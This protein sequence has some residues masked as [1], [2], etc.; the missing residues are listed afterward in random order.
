MSTNSVALFAVISLLVGTD[1]SFD[2]VWT[3]ATG[4]DG[5]NEWHST[6]VRYSVPSPSVGT[7]DSE[8][9]ILAELR[10]A[11]Q[12]VAA[13]ETHLSTQR[14]SRASLSA[15]Q[16]RAS[17][18]SRYQRIA[19]LAVLFGLSTL[20]FAFA[21]HTIRE[22]ESKR[23]EIDP[24][25][26][27]DIP[28]MSRIL[29]ACALL[30]VL[31]GIF[32]FT[33][34]FVFTESERYLSTAEALYLS[35]QTITAVGYGD[36]N[37]AT[38]EGKIFMLFY[39]LVA[40]ALIGALLQNVITHYI[41]FHVHAEN[42]KHLSRFEIAL[43]STKPLILCIVFGTLFYA[44][45]PGE[46]KTMFES[47]YMSVVTLSNI[48]FGQ[49]H[50]VTEVGQIVASVWMI[51]GVVCFFKFMG[52]FT[53]ALFQHRRNIRSEA[54]AW[55]VFNEIDKS[56]NGYITRVQFL[57]YDLI[58]GGLERVRFEKALKKFN[59]FDLKHNHLLDFEEFKQYIENP[60]SDSPAATQNLQESDSSS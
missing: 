45:C 25:W 10:L 42:D 39:V 29:G 30:Y 1:A 22:Y 7:S 13:L 3:S 2:Q 32:C 51:V 37:P 59:K 16:Q 34:I 46:D 11:K 57:G 44:Y 33:E 6:C 17:P 9:Q 21:W 28:C 19:K 47:L 15:Q 54:A 4:L 31:L 24:P 40:V 38:I 20:G 58:Q 23:D 12:R 56:H 50:P 52:D 60:D 5:D 55:K 41:E 35:S 26:F 43:S 27:H 49:H 14:S 18:S 36:L 8:E 48:G 53:S